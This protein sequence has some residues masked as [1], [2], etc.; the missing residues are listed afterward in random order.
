MGVMHEL[1]SFIEEKQS[2]GVYPHGDAQ[3]GLG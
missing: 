1:D 3:P 2:Q